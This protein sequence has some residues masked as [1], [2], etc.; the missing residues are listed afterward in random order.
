MNYVILLAD[1]T[2]AEEHPNIQGLFDAIS[3]VQNAFATILKTLLYDVDAYSMFSSTNAGTALVG[4]GNTLLTL[5]MLM[6]ICTF[7]FNVELKQSFESSIRLAMRTILM[8]IIVENVPNVLS[9]CFGVF[10]E[11]NKNGA[12]IDYLSGANGIMKNVTNTGT[13]VLGNLADMNPGVLN[14]NFILVGLALIVVLVAYVLISGAV[15]MQIMGVVFEQVVCIF[16]SPIATATLVNQQVR[17]TGISFIKNCVTVNIQI[18]VMWVIMFAW[19]KFMSLSTLTENFEIVKLPW[20]YGG[21]AA[22]DFKNCAGYAL[23]FVTPLFWLFILSC[24]LKK[25]NEMTRRALG[26]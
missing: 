18:A 26:G 22:A 7:A 13:E 12:L 6:E 17:Q 20:D 25:A 15:L 5:F 10:K 1:A 4:I 24:M 3:S 11:I 23:E 16:V 8:Y 14:I 19:D 2:F 21:D 9:M